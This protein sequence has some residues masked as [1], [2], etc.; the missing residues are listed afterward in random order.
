MSSHPLNM[1]ELK[2]E[3]KLKKAEQEMKHRLD[4]LEERNTTLNNCVID[5]QARSMRDN[6][7]FHNIT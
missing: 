1:H 3:N 2:E 5:L 6:L 7:L 4:A